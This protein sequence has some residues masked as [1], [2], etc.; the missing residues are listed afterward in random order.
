MNM[1]QVLLVD[2]EPI[3]LSGIKYLIDWEKNDCQIIDTARNGKQALEK[4]RTFTPDI[5]I[6]DIAM[7]VI[8]GT[9]LLAMAAEESPDTVFIMLTNHPD[10][11]LARESLRF[12]AVD[13]LLKS[14][15]VAETLE[16]SLARA[17]RERDKRTK[18][19]RVELVDSYL[20][21]GEERALQSAVCRLAHPLGDTDLHE[22]AAVLQRHGNLNGWG[23]VYIPIDFSQAKSYEDAP[24][25]EKRRLSDW[26]SDMLN[27]LADNLFPQHLLF[28]PDKFGQ[29]LFLLV[30]GTSQEQ[31]E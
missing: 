21:E 24:V 12:K 7:P 31:W 3:I 30:W 8:S 10:F 15:L 17:R 2:D 14:Q 18:L 16:A 23:M 5:V 22:T 27:K 4:I 19:T 13:Y 29:Q 28:C 26:E 11:H 20:A 25:S 9:E 1:Y 6:C